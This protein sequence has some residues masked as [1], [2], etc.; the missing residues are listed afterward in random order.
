M[1]H[2]G[3]WSDWARSSI[4]L[5]HRS[6][7]A[8]DF[9]AIV[10][11]GLLLYGLNVD[12]ILGGDAA[13]YADY[14]LQAKFDE[15]SLHIGYYAVVFAAD[16]TI[17]HLLG[18][19]IQELMVWINVVAGA[20][21]LGIAYLLARHFLA[22]RRDA[23]LCVVVLAVSG[24][25]LTN[26]TTSEIYMLQT[27]AT[28][29]S[30]LLFVRERQASAGIAAG[31]AMLVSPLSVFAFLFFPVV[32]YQRSGTIRWR[33]L[34]R[35]GVWSLAVYLP[36][37]TV[38]WRELLWGHR[39]LLN[40]NGA[41]PV[42]LPAMLGHFALFQAK[43]YTAL[44]VLLIP[45]AA[46]VRRH[47]RFLALSLAVALPH[48]Y[49]I[50]KL[51][52]EDNVFILTTDF[53]FA[54]WLVIGWRQLERSALGRRVAAVPLVAHVALLV[55]AG[56]LFSVDPH[57]EYASEM[58]RIARRYVL[59]R[60]AVVLSDWSR[61]MVLTFYG[62]PAVVSTIER[63]RLYS[64]M[65]GIPAAARRGGRSLEG[66]TIYL[67]DGWEPGPLRR[68]F[69]TRAGLDSAAQ[70]HAFLAE[71]RRALDLDCSL[72]HEATVRLYRCDARAGEG[73]GLPVQ[74]RPEAVPVSVPGTSAP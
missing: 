8:F 60:N 57:R 71:A 72:V 66:R 68:L 37:L 19:P 56:A 1:R 38:L 27:C 63:D 13:M 41:V 39:G 21:T 25:V 46:A 62:R 28:L 4:A 51:T 53:F 31:V 18:I 11:A 7:G 52:G 17:G 36:Y 5:A 6:P 61:G 74:D 30:F 73:S 50:S 10:L 2:R 15:L 16:R 24:R 22:A 23:L 14:V 49:V 9:G 65:T 67:L 43:Q 55:A 32:D 58:R 45:A 33:V 54:C 70:R 47:A 29:L 35:F 3:R 40:V 69:S 42:D 64:Q 26:A 59:D 34:G 20:F 12:F 44:L 48:L